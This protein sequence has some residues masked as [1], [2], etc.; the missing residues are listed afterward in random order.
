MSHKVLQNYIYGEW[1]DSVSEDVLDVINPTTGEIIAQVPLSTAD[2][3]NQVVE[4]AHAAFEEWRETTPFTRARYMFRLKNLMEE[5]FE[6]LAQ[7]IVQ[8]H[9]KIID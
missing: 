1:V 3:A 5:R 7:I 6:E 9:G 2:E 8:E 4:A